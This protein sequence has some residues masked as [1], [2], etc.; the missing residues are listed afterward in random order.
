MFPQAGRVLFFIR[1]PLV[2]LAYAVAFRN[3]MVPSRTPFLTAGILLALISV[4][5]LFLQYEFAPV[6]D[7]PLALYGFRNYFLYIPLAFVVAGSFEAQDVSRLMRWTL[8][9]S[10]PIA[11]LVYF[12]FLSPAS[13]PI[14]RG[15][16]QT[17]DLQYVNAGVA[18]NIVRTWGTFT[19]SPGQAAFIVTSVGMVLNAWMRPN[20][21][22][23]KRSLLFAATAAVATCLVL[24]GSRGVVVWCGL[25]FGVALVAALMC[26]GKELALRLLLMP[27]VLVVAGALVV[28]TAFPRAV[29][30]F[31]ER[32]RGAGEAESVTYGAGGVFA[33][34]AYDLVSF[35]SLI[36]DTPLEGYQLGIG[37]NAADILGLR[38]R[39]LLVGRDQVAG[40]ESD[41]GRQI[42][43]LGP[44]LGV[45]FILFRVA[46]VM[47]LG[48][49]AIRA[50]RRSRQPLPMLLF[51]F[52]GVLLFNGQ[53][54]GH[55]SL[56]GYG[57]LF[58]GILMAVSKGL[59][60]PRIDTRGCEAVSRGGFV[61]Q[62]AQP[63]LARNGNI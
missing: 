26:A 48:I 32:W 20:P 18:G 6:F 41:W 46:F 5:L 10:L 43:E 3:R 40:A 33:R 63:R 15:M 14:N 60:R 16:G 35:T 34:A 59:Q 44:T 25:V 12:Q 27:V 57:W 61:G 8:W 7:W 17:A 24:C 45:V 62:T 2:L 31:G 58:A 37:G 55:G 13:A 9:F 22:R 51:A 53:I 1:D 54:T 47:A 4:P 56:N 11:V 52:V 23:T 39:I 38:N 42:L 28:P 36:P 19:S 30:S 49:E 29:D 21:R 50:T